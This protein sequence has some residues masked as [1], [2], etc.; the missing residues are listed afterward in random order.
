MS[1]ESNTRKEQN[2]RTNN[3]Y[4]NEFTEKENFKLLAKVLASKIENHEIKRICDVGCATGE[5]LCYLIRSFGK[6]N[7]DYYGIDVNEQYI[8]LCKERIPNCNFIK[9]DIYEGI[10]LSE[11]RRFDCVTFFGT[12]CLFSDFKQVFRNLLSLLRSEGYLY[13]FSPFNQ[14]GYHV[15]YEYIHRATNGKMIKDVE[16]TCSIEEISE[17]LEERNMSYIWHSFRMPIDIIHSNEKYPVRAWT[18]LLNSGER[19]TR[20]AI[21]RIQEQFLLEIRVGSKN[22]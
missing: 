21:D 22:S 14:Y 11:E 9:G 2:I 18:E 4:I 15:K 12:L 3:F 20:D 5:L 16:Y 19:I 10:L 1:D 13:V 8:S 6:D 17:W 7:I